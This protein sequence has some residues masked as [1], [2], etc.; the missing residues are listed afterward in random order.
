VPKKSIEIS[1]GSVFIV[2]GYK[3]RTDIVI[4]TG[5]KN[6][7]FSS[8]CKIEGDGFSIIG[9]PGTTGPEN[10]LKVI[11]QFPIEMVKM[12]MIKYWEEMIGSPLDKDLLATIDEEICGKPRRISLE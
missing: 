7:F 1:V 10:I 5:E 11:K 3:D 4:N 2:P 6:W 12:R 9:S 8:L